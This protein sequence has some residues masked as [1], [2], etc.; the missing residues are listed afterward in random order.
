MMKKILLTCS[1]FVSLNALA[2]MDPLT[3]RNDEVSESEI[4]ASRACFSEV[5]RIG[6]KSPH[7]SLPEFRSCMSENYL[8]LSVDCRKFFRELYGPKN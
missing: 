7:E 8:S 1:L 4:N 3:F 6:C 2:S 5:E